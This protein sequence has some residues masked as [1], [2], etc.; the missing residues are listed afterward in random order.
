VIL[1]AA[2]G[3]NGTQGA[4]YPAAYDPVIA[5]GSVDPNLQPSSFS[6]YGPL[7]DIWAP[8]RDILTTSAMA[9]TDW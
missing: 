7:I 3:N 8:G 2:A 4:L 9:V 6:N 5:V 1:V